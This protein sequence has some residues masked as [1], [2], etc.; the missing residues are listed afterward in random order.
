[1]SIA[2]KLNYTP[3]DL[4]SM[5]DRG[6]QDL[7][8]GQL[9]ERHVSFETSMI[10]LIINGRL[11]AHVVANKLGWVAQSDGGLQIFDDAPM[12]VRFADGAFVSRARS[13]HRPGDGHLRVAPDLVIEVVSPIDVAAEIDV[14]VAEYLNA[15]VRLIWVVYPE[16]RAVNV[17]RPGGQDSRL[18]ESETLSGEDVVPGF[19]LPVAEIFDF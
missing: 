11:M 4:L 12:K 8:D 7:I 1:M 2:T 19:E 6:V 15:G 16:T 5:P 14:K 9:V 3:E 17:F 18:T 10:A 13:P